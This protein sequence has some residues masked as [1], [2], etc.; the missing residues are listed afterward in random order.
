MDGSL[1]PAVLVKTRPC[2]AL[3]LAASA[4]P[5]CV[6]PDGAVKSV[7]EPASWN[8]TRTSTSPDTTP[9]GRAIVC[10]VVTDAAVVW[11]RYAAVTPTPRNASPPEGGGE[12]RKALR[13]ETGG[14][15][16]GY[17]FTRRRIGRTGVVNDRSTPQPRRSMRAPM[18][19]TLMP[20]SRA[21]SA[22][23]LVTPW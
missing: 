4:V 9:E 22:S 18:V 5:I 3:L 7:A 17:A 14:L 23:V 2:R 1:P 20:V 8:W 15:Q 12:V 10:G 6:H 11:E 13:P 19:C 21:H 16:Q